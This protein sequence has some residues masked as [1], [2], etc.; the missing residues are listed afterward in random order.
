MPTYHYVCD[1]CHHEFECFQ[2]MTDPA[3]KVCPRD[4]CGQKK[5]GRGKVRRVLSGGAGVIFKGS[6]FY[7]TDYRSEGYKQAAKK[8]ADTA[9]PKTDAVKGAS[10]GGTEKKETK[11]AKPKE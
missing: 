5:W 4:Q 1:K 8:E 3:L 2:P 11:A 6:G 10:G 7:A 9:A